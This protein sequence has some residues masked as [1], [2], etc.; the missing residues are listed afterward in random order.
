MWVIYNVNT[1]VMY[2]NPR[3]K[4]ETWANRHTAQREINRMRLDIFTY[5]MADKAYFHKRIEKMEVV[6]SIHDRKR[7]RPITQSVNT[8]RCCDPSSELYHSM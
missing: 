8:P 6:Y 5:A 1:T 4:R 2:R 3:T 7:E